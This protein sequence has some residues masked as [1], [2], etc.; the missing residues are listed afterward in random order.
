MAE[1][2]RKRSSGEKHTITTPPTD[3]AAYTGRASRWWP[4]AGRA[5][6]P[7]PPPTAPAAGAPPPCAAAAAA[8]R[9]APTAEREE[10]G[11]ARKS[12]NLTV[13]SKELV[14]NSAGWVCAHL[15]T[16]TCPSWQSQSVCT[17]APVATS[18]MLTLLPYPDARYRS[19][20]QL[21]WRLVKSGKRG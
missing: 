12:H 7:P 4:P 18:K 9:P 1:A 16:L 17:T 10:P 5:G 13:L 20:V 19:S 6:T 2:R 21:A 15:H 8:A 3:V 11:G 14:A